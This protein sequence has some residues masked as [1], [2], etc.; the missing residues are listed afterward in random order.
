MR[1]SKHAILHLT[2]LE[3]LMDVVYGIAIWRL[4]LQLPR[5]DIDDP[6][7][8]SVRELLAG[9]WETYLVV[10]LATVIVVVYWLQSNDLYGCLEKTDTVHSILSIAQLCCVLLFLYAIGVGLRLGADAASRAF[11]SAAALAFGLA[12]FASWRY[13]TTRG[14][15]LRDD[16]TPEQVAQ[17][18]RRNLAEPLIAAL[19]IPF[20][21]FGPWAWEASW[22]LY[23]FLRYALGR[24]PQPRPA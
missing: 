14:G 15:L 22:F 23:P 8:D 10:A 13:A 24:Q 20:A 12:A 4:F 16:T 6:A 3:R 19:T 2:R 11:E 18:A 5:P 9:S 7:W 17:L 1:A 21:F